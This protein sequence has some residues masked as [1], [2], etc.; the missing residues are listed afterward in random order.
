MVKI[1]KNITSGSMHNI[2]FFSM[3]KAAD[4][5]KNMLKVSRIF[6][7]ILLLYILSFGNI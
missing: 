4:T 1:N 3:F 5:L 7:A 6:Q 2:H